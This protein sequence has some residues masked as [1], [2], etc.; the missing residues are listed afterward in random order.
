MK[1]VDWKRPE[2]C[3][4]ECHTPRIWEEIA[5]AAEKAGDHERAREAREAGEREARNMGA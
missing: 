5:E 4:T 3:D 1:T 2:D